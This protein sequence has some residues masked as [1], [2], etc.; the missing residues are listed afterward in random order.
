MTA[1]AVVGAGSAAVATAQVAAARDTCHIDLRASSLE[2]PV[3]SPLTLTWVATGADHL[4]A[5]WTTATPPFAGTVTTTRTNPGTYDYQVTGTSNGTFCGGDKVQ[6]TFARRSAPGGSS[7]ASSSPTSASSSHH[8][9]GSGT[10]S[11]T[12][13]PRAPS[14][15]SASP[16]RSSAAGHGGK[17]SGK[18]GRHGTK[19]GARYPSQSPTSGAGVPWYR[20]PGELLTLAVLAFGGALLIG[21]RDSVRGSLVHSH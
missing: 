9:G 10:T 5:S 14:S 3:G 8:S 4:I 1:L 13:T 16:T 19:G 2:L 18:N 12:S 11:A 17:G 20:Q 15:H 6:V 21:K 7:S